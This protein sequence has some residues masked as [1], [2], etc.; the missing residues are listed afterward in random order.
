MFIFLVH[1]LC[2]RK[3]LDEG[4][5]NFGLDP[6]RTDRFVRNNGETCGGRVSMLVPVQAN[7]Q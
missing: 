4:C 2:M 6:Q 3:Y 5:I 1:T 7:I